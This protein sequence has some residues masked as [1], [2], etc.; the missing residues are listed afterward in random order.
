VTHGRG[1]VLAAV[2]FALLCAISAGSSRA[3]TAGSPFYLV[4]SPTKE[5]SNV[6]SCIAVTGPWVVVPA[7]GEATYLVKCPNRLNFL[8][9]GTDAQASS[10]DI[11]VWW[12]GPLGAPLGTP[13]H[14][15]SPISN[16]GTVLLFHAV[17]NDGRMG[18]FQPSLGCIKLQATT[19]RS[20]LS[21]QALSATPAATPSAALDL[22]AKI[23]LLG[24]GLTLSAKSSCVRKEK[25]VGSWYSL[26]FETV[27]PPDLAHVD[28]VAVQTKVHD[29][30]VSAVITTK[31]SLP[32]PPQAEVQLGAMCEP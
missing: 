27:A 7:T 30:A 10:A 12:D 8:T 18:S 25:L 11:R 5:C 4:P 2:A 29:N 28:A 9:G 23:I 14:R 22:R 31:D 19:K 6:Q 21:A 26:A 13:L 20:T 3:T 16:A 1:T 17:S 15:E 32:E 24:P